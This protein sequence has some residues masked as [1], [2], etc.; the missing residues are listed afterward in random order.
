MSF[1]C[2]SSNTFQ[3]AIQNHTTW[4]VHNDD[5]V[6]QHMLQKLLTWLMS[7]LWCFP[8][9][10]VPR[11][12]PWTANTQSV[13][14]LTMSNTSASVNLGF[15]FLICYTGGIRQGSGTLSNWLNLELAIQLIHYEK[16]AKA[17]EE[18]K[19]EQSYKTY[20]YRWKIFVFAVHNCLEQLHISLPQFKH[21]IIR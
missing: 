8:G 10:D 16:K 4:K 21:I 19:E 20:N 14:V 9:G 11:S 2:K 17:S 7:S 6:T 5:N 18:L 15:S 13:L 1:C 12:P 3:E